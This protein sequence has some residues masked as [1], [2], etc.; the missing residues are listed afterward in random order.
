MPRSRSVDGNPELFHFADLTLNGADVLDFYKSII[1]IPASSMRSPRNSGHRFLRSARLAYN[2][3]IRNPA[4]VNRTAFHPLCLKA[5]P[6][7]VMPTH[8]PM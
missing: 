6:V 2:G 7:Q 1:N 4:Q 5:K 3:T 8:P